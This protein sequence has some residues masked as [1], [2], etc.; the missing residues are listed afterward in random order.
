MAIQYIEISRQNFSKDYVS[1]F[2]P[3]AAMAIQHH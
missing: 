2:V 3:A 1:E